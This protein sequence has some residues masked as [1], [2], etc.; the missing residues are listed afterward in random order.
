MSLRAL[1]WLSSFALHGAVVG[2]FLISPGGAALEEGVGED[3]FIVEQ[4]VYSERIEAVEAPPPV[5]LAAKPVEEI[6]PIEEDIPHVVGSEAGPEQDVVLKEL[7]EDVKEVK[8]EQKVAVAQPTE[9]AVEEQKE[10]GEKKTGGNQTAMSAYRGKLFT[11]ISKKKVNPRSKIA[12]VVVV[13][14]TVGPAG[15]LISREV[16]TSSGSKLLDD[17]AVQ[18]IERA[19][20][21]PKMPEDAE[22]EPM[23]VSV[24]FKFSVR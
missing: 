9:L 4:G 11:H 3:T 19:A 22:K 24:P 17:A 13:R 6:K 8:E 7:P 20:P 16:A 23:V 12:G 18:S 2:F 15:E 1:T 5:P 21:F 10:T 14:F